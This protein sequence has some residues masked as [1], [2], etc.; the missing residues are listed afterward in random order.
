MA[1]GF[2]MPKST[3]PNG[4]M[5]GKFG[6]ETRDTIVAFQ[7]KHELKVDGVVG[8]ET[9]RSLDAVAVEKGLP[10]RK[11]RFFPPKKKEEPLPEG[12][13]FNVEYQNVRNIG[14][15]RPTSC[16]GALQFDIKQVHKRGKTCPASLAGKNLD[17][18]VTVISNE[19]TC[20]STGGVLTGSC[21]LGADGTPTSP[22]TDTYAMCFPK[23]HRDIRSQIEFGIIPPVPCQGKMRQELIIDGSVIEVKIITFQV[24]FFIDL[25]A[26]PDFFVCPA[27]VSVA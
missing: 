11:P 23:N 17:E 14:F 4:E 25:N 3:E 21:P 16:G 6:Q 8:R 27:F 10:P 24:T 22:C 26:P 15:C 12:C 9:L 5:D 20:P 13:E 7:E 2:A 19:T 18:R 1:D